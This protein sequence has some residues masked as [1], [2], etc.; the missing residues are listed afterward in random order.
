MDYEAITEAA[1]VALKW[2]EVDDNGSP[3]DE[4]GLDFSDRA[5]RAIAQDVANFMQFEHVKVY[6]FE[7]SEAQIGHDFILTRNYHGVGFWDRGLGDAG[8]RLTDVAHSFGEVHAYIN[9]AN[10]SLEV[11]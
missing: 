1:L 8:E 6:A 7:L 10:R 9:W 2:S 5:R 4:S 3:L 11:E